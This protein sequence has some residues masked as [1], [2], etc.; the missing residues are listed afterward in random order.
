MT[1]PQIVSLERQFRKRCLMAHYEIPRLS[2][3][4]M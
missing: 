4:Y 1:G 3:F 2:L